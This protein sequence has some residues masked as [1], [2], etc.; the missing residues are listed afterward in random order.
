MLVFRVF[1]P[2]NGMTSIDL[3]VLCLSQVVANSCC[4]EQGLVQVR[5]LF[6]G[7]PLGI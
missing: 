7:F 5:F 6:A 2:V 1:S 3:G 4:S